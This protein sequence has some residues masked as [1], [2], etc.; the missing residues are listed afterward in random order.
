MQPHS[1]HWII[2]LCVGNFLI[3]IVFRGETRTI[4]PSFENIGTT[5]RLAI[6]HLRLNMDALAVYRNYMLTLF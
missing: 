2:S 6:P 1:G 4:Y 5:N 3:F